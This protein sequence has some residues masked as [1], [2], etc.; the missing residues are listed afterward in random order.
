MSGY[1]L[2]K[3]GE[4]IEL[5]G[6]TLIGRSDDCDL[7]IS[8]GH[9]SRRHAVLTITDDG[10]WLEDLESANGTYVNERRISARTKLSSG[11]RVSFD[12][13]TFAFEAPAP[14][15][16]DGDATVVRRIPIDDG[17]TVVRPIPP[18]PP[19]PAPAPTPA[20]P[21]AARNPTPAQP[22]AVKPAPEPAAKP[23]PAVE[24]KP[25]SAPEPA[26]RPQAT[27][28][29]A[30]AAPPAAAKPVPRSWADP[31]YQNEQGTRMFTPD[32]LKA[33][34]AGIGDQSA[35]PASGIEG[36][37]LQVT[38]GASA[39]TVLLLGDD[40]D[41]W[42][43]GTDSDRDLSIT[44]PGVSAY[45]AK[46]TRE[47]QRW[48]VIDQMSANGTF[49]NEQKGAVSFLSSG[50]RI[51]FGPVECTVVLPAGGKRKVAARKAPATAAARK[52]GSN[53]TTWIIAA[54]TAIGTIALMVIV[55][56]F[57]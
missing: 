40:K 47:G 35:A 28:A 20:E 14:V 25:E 23:A 3:D 29:P 42:T 38:K 50:D 13:V 27:A 54:L 11:D 21:A 44:D 16:D 30:N 33:L 8:E 24:R 6:E 12:T 46:I 41:E 57:I 48:K 55:L 34:T 4:K 18:A 52:R 19:P 7:K 51:R 37:H 53:K 31:E 5:E 56:N 9:P 45:H 17:A 36:A 2:S 10:A 15:A 32:E 39:G 26:A 49:V 22:E 1:F 43:V